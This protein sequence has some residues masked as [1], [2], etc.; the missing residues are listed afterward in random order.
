MILPCKLPKYLKLLGLAT[1]SPQL[2]ER[3]SAKSLLLVASHEECSVFQPQKL[4]GHCREA[5]QC[6]MLQTVGRESLGLHLHSLDEPAVLH[7]GGEGGQTFELA[8]SVAVEFDSAVS[9]VIQILEPLVLPELTQ[10]SLLVL[11]LGLLSKIEG[12]L[13]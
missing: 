7:V 5:I 13:L 9:R 10:S 1:E 3:L 2:E 11:P 8:L 4:L 6:V 12:P